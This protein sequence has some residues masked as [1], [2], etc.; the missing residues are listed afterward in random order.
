MKK[1]LIALMMGL[2]LI[3]PASA[4]Q[5]V[6]VNPALECRTFDMQRAEVAA[7]RPDVSIVMD[8]DKE[9]VVIYQQEEAAGTYFVASHFNEDGCLDGILVMNEDEYN[10]YIGTAI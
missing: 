7:A 4:A 6:E 5:F 2:A 8:M 3:M 10:E 9:G 1:I